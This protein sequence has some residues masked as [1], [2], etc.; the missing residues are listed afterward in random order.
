MGASLGWIMQDIDDI[1]KGAELP[2]SKYLPGPG[3]AQRDFKESLFR[4]TRFIHQ[5]RIENARSTEPGA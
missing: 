2:G 4:A 1:R 3:N 5:W